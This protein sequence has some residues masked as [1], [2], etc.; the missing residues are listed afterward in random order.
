MYRVPYGNGEVK[1]NCFRPKGVYSVLEKIYHILNNE[2]V[3]I[4]HRRVFIPELD[5]LVQVR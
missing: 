3:F 2:S 4:R 5:S 1:T